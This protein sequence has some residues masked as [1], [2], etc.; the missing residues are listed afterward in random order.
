MVDTS[1]VQSLSSCSNTDDNHDDLLRSMRFL[2]EK[3]FDEGWQGLNYDFAAIPY[4]HPIAALACQMTPPQQGYKGTFH[5]FTDGSSL[6][7]KSAWAF[8]VINEVVWYGQRYFFRIG[9]ASALV[10]EDLDP[11]TSSAMDAEATAIIAGVEYILSRQLPADHDG[12]DVTFHYDALAVGHGACGHQN[13][14]QSK[15]QSSERQ[16]AAR[17][18]LSILQQKASSVKGIHVKAHNGHPWNE[19]ADSI[20]TLTRKGWQPPRP[21]LLRSG[22]LLQHPLRDWAWLEVCPNKELPG[23]DR[24]LSNEHA[25]P[26]QGLCD[27]QLVPGSDW[28][29]GRIP[30]QEPGHVDSIPTDLSEDTYTLSLRMATMNVGTLYAVEDPNDASICSM[31]AAEILRQCQLERLHAVGVQESRA[32][33]NQMLVH[34]PFIRLIS[35]SDRGQAGVELWLDTDALA[36]IFVTDFQ[37]EKDICVWHSDSRILA[38][39]CQFGTSVIEFCGHVCP[40]AG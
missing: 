25:Q 9:Y 26:N 39:R 7:H 38:A 2:L 28:P 12:I 37:P 32:R 10:S 31:K 22:S 14:P 15:E 29:L 20:A 8:V 17:I 36:K 18:M 33:Q 16:H 13:T 5:V 27:P 4:L 34:G 19:C 40:A 3:L 21:A 35:K 11:V 1:G 23:L 30:Q 6:R 24:I